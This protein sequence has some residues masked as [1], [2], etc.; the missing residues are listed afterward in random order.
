MG[1][2]TCWASGSVRKQLL[3]VELDPHEAVI[4]VI[5]VGQPAEPLTPPASRRR[6]SPDQFCRGAW[7]DWPEQL[8]DAAS[9]LQQA[10]SAMN[11]QPWSLYVTAEGAFVLDASDRALL[12]AGIALCHVELALETPHVWCF[13]RGRGEPLAWAVAL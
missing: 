11:M 2:G 13:G 5:C 10:P 12:E 1:L 6:K 9:L 7:R 8:L 4:C 3:R